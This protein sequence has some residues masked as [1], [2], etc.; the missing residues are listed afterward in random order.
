MYLGAHGL[1]GQCFKFVRRTLDRWTGRMPLLQM[2]ESELEQL[3]QDSDT[4]YVSEL[5][6]KHDNHDGVGVKGIHGPPSTTQI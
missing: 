1:P 4:S 5:S 6:N 3:W 2:V